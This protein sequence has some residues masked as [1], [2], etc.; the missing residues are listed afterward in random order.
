LIQNYGNDWVNAGGSN[1]TYDANN[2]IL[3][4]RD[5]SY[6]ANGNKTW[7]GGVRYYYKNEITINS[8]NNDINI[9]PNP[10]SGV[11][12]IQSSNE[13]NSYAIYDITGRLVP[14]H[15]TQ[16]Q[17]PVFNPFMNYNYTAIDLSDLSNGIYNIN[18]K[19]NAGAVNKRLIIVR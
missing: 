16:E 13:L 14:N 4:E 6:S 8:N 19:S 9:Y 1:Y 2:N 15:A 10:S 7:D 12:F 11:F 3:T 5:M 18:I 17:S